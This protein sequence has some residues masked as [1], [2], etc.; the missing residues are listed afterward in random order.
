MTPPLT[1]LSAKLAETAG[2]RQQG[3]QLRYAD[4]ATFGNI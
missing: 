3:N 2:N 4:P 1:P